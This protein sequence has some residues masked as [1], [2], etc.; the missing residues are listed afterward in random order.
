MIISGGY[1]R[2]TL[3]ISTY[4]HY[5]KACYVFDADTGARLLALQK[6]T[7][8]L[9]IKLNPKAVVNAL[10]MPSSQSND[11]HLIFGH[12][13]KR[14]IVKLLTHQ[15]PGRV[16]DIPQARITQ[17]LRSFQTNDSCGGCRASKARAKN[18]QSAFVTPATR[19]LERISADTIYFYK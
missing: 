16:I 2:D 6:F 17:L 12:F 14:R 19:P 13:N 3:H 7:S 9:T 8:Y 4:D 5:S 18:T 1:L 11:A 10:M 15:A